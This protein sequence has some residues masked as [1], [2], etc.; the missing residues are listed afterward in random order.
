MERAIL[1]AVARAD[2]II[3]QAARIAR[4]IL[5]LCGGLWLILKKG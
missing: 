4:D 2:L 5:L 1:V 3:C